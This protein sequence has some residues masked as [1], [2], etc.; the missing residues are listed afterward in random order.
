MA[1]IGGHGM[2]FW[3]Q[4]GGYFVFALFIAVSILGALA[5]GWWRRYQRRVA[6]AVETG[7]TVDKMGYGFID[8]GIDSLAMVLRLPVGV[9][10]AAELVN[11]TKLPM[12]WKQ[13]GDLEWSE[14]V[15]KGDPIKGAIFVAEAAADGSQL[16]LVRGRD[17]IGMPMS[18]KAWAKIRRVVAKTATD[19]GI[20]AHE[21]QGTA[22]VRVPRVDTTGMAPAM[23]ANTPHFWERPG[24]QQWP[25]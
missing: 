25:R 14:P 4:W 23:V 9:E 20:G 1:A 6:K 3:Q 8:R 19:R 11:A 13:T 2:T 5:N 24:V 12:F 7:A 17:S 15:A 21:E 18:D 16:A 22:L 10:Q